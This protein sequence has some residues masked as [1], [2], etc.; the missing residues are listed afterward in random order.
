MMENV[1]FNSF[2]TPSRLVQPKQRILLKIF[3]LD[4]QLDDF[5]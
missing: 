3:D 4:Q 1:M 2:F 5:D